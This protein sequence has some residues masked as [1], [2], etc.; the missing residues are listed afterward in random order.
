MLKFLLIFIL[1]VMLFRMLLRL[2]LPSIVR[3]VYLTMQQK[4]QSNPG[5]Q[6]PEGSIFVS[7]EAKKESRSDSQDGEYIDFKE[8]K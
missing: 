4:M 2:F 8:I 7:G 1:I 5:P 6:K 3:T